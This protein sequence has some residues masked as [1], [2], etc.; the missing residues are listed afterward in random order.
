MQ[1]DHAWWC[2]V[3]NLGPLSWRMSA[4]QLSSSNASRY[5]RKLKREFNGELCGKYCRLV[6]IVYQLLL[7]LSCSSLFPA[8]TYGGH[9]LLYTFYRFTK[10]LCAFSVSSRIQEGKWERIVRQWNQ[11]K[12]IYDG[13][14]LEMKEWMALIYMERSGSLKDNQDKQIYD[15]NRVWD[16]RMKG[17]DLY[18]EVWISTGIQLYHAIQL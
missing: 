3:L 16:E 5:Q 11:D 10:K 2:E 14:E 4:Y 12:Q 8:R 7:S 1:Y 15:G 18:G 9:T 17:Y 6:L 13:T